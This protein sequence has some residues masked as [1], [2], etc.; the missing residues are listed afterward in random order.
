VIV[1]ALWLAVGA[2]PALNDWL[3]CRRAARRERVPMARAR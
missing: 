1:A 3:A 2:W